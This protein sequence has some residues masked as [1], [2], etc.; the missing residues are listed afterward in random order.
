MDNLNW[1]AILKDIELGQAVLLIGQGVQAD[2]QAHLHTTLKATLAE[3]LLYFY[4][5]DGLFLFQDSLA[6]TDARREAASIFNDTRPEDALLKKIGEMP[7]SL[8][9]SANPDKALCALFAQ[10]H[11]KLQFDYLS[12]NP[13]KAVE[14]AVERP[15]VEKPLLYNLC[16]SIEDQE[17]LI[18]D[19]DDLFKLFKTL[20]ADLKIPEYQVRIPLKK[21]TTFIFLSEKFEYTEG[22]LAA[23]IK[24]LTTAT[25]DGKTVTTTGVEAFQL[26]IVCEY[27]ESLVKEGKV[28]YAK[29]D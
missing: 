5:H 9:V 15:S 24:A 3:R 23:I 7:F 2:A 1:D 12:S 25:V 20:L 10:Y 18:L 22:G 16:G 6:K 21:A 28:P 13:S 17:S 11:L 29:R 19:Y 14:Y 27:I 26:Q 4:R 8:M